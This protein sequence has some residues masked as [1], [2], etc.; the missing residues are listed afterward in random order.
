MAEDM[1]KNADP[2][3]EHIAAYSRW[4]SGGWGSLLTG[5]LPILPLFVILKAAQATSKSPADIAVHSD[6]SLQ[7]PRSLKAH[8]RSGNAGHPHHKKK[9]HRLL[10]SSYILGGKARPRLATEGSSSLRSRH[11]RYH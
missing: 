1:A 9:E 5:K 4:G 7:S 10:Y 8:A 2:G 3:E 11:L 6:P